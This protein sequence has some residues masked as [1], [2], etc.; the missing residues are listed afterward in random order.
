MTARGVIRFAAVAAA[1]G[2]VW[3]L[4]LP[5]VGRLPAVERHVAAMEAGHVNPAAMVYTE[6]DRLP[7]RPHWVEDR[8]ILWP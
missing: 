7:L 3:C 4:V 5:L 6:L 1:L 8:L 2:F